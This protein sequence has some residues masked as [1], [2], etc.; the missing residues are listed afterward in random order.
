MAVTYADV[1]KRAGTSTAVV[2]YVFN[3]GPRGVAP[4]TRARVL[5]AAQE[6]GYRPNRL[7]AGLRSGSTGFVGVLVPDSSIPFFAELTR[8][9]IAELGKRGFLA[10]VSHAGLSGLAE[11]ATIDAL[12]SAKV[13][14]LLLTAFSREDHPQLDLDIPVVYVHHKP[15]SSDAV[16]IESD[17]DHATRLA[18]EHLRWHGIEPAFWTGPD[19]EGPLGVRTRAWQDS[20]GTAAEPLR[21]A[22]SAGDAEAAFLSLAAEGGVPRGIVVATDQQAVGILAGAYEAGIRVPDELALISLDG[23]PETAFTSPPLTVV[24]QPLEEMV[25][26]AVSILAND[27]DRAE[28]ISPGRLVLRR[29]CGCVPA[30]TPERPDRL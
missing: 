13:D 3:D 24:Q 21:S 8:T 7:A 4:K 10:L 19:D 6:L 2:S 29:S 9:M 25:R 17:N 5:K 11:T 23:S 12:L 28:H 30:R 26:Q 15:P 20:L 22:F 16:L 27:Q 18:V 14:G 1:A